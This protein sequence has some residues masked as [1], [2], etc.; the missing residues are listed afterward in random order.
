MVTEKMINISA[1]IIARN[2]EKNIEKTINCLI[3][4]IL[5]FR[6][7]IIINDGSTDNTRELVESYSDYLE[8]VE[9][10]NLPYHEQSYAGSLEL[11]HSIN[12]GLKRIKEHG[13]PD[14]ILQSGADHKY[15]YD[16][17]HKIIKR[18]QETKCVIASGTFEGAKL[19]IDTPL[20][21]GK[22]INA[23][24]FNEVNNMVYPEKY[25]YESWID[26]RAM[27]EGLKVKRFDDIITGI[28]PIEMNKIK[29]FNWGRC[30][31][32]LGGILPFALI[33]SNTFKEYKIDY[34]KGYFSRKGVQIHEDIF[35]YV[36][37]IQWGRSKKQVYSIL[38]RWLN[39]K[40]VY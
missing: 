6:E 25:G 31:Y 8:Y 10:I 7:I 26:Y 27:K 35:D 9:L 22:I 5:P 40:D 23:N 33:R 32:A 37:S 34:L 29:A 17:T 14:Y 12:M 4:Q 16:Y 28:R 24:F 2:E 15:D 13:V 1:F 19:N 30:T 39:I 20:G 21:S 18:I 38:K 11:G 3:K 36:G